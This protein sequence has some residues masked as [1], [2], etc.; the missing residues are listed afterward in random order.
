M[1]SKNDDGCKAYVRLISFVSCRDFDYN[2]HKHHRYHHKHGLYT[3]V[4]WILRWRCHNLSQIWM[5]LFVFG[6]FDV[7]AIDL[8]PLLRIYVRCMMRGRVN[9][10]QLF[11]FG[12]R[13]TRLVFFYSMAS[14]N[15]YISYRLLWR[16]NESHI[17]HRRTILGFTSFARSESGPST[18]QTRK[19][20]GISVIWEWVHATGTN[21]CQNELANIWLLW[22]KKE[23]DGK[24]DCNGF[25][26]KPTTHRGPLFVVLFF[27]SLY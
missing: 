5:L 20:N 23:S 3:R 2:N 18:Y 17:E 16:H 7:I 24:I 10:T 15:L 19:H 22:R 4:P 8:M 21:R 1:H 11:I 25:S 26:E 12:N 6:S 13:R 27:L 9:F 14:M